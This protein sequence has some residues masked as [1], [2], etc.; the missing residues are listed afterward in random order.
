MV[1]KKETSFLDE[2]LDKYG[3]EVAIRKYKK[4]IPA[5]STGSLGID[6]STGIGGIPK[7][8]F[9][10]IYGADGS[11]KTT[12]LLNIAK[13]ALLAGERVAFIDTENSLDYAYA[14]DIIGDFDSDGLIIIQPESAE[15]SFEIALSAID[16]GYGVILF[17]SVAALS[18][19]KELEN[20]MDKAQVALAPR[21][22]SKFLRKVAFKVRQKEVAFVFTNQVRANM[23][24][25]VG[26]WTTPAGYALKHYVSLKIFLQRSDEIK[27]GEDVIGHFIKFTIKKNKVGKPY[28]QAT[29]NIIWGKGIDFYR[30][31]LSFG[32]LLGVIKNRGSYF[33]F[34]DETIGNK[35]GAANTARALG[36]DKEL[37]DKIVEMCYNVAGSKRYQKEEQ[38]KEEQKSVKRENDDGKNDGG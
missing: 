7:G 25:Y 11:G 4:G 24:S 1:K 18:P 12:L 17:D 14:H 31:V 19:E 6:V 37:L 20:R 38:K 22:T 15:D 36:K 34:E 23:G 3:E 27:D 2:I 8:R 30:D 29:T 21:L 32:T 16:H 26:G 28:R 35:P 5:I 9:T 33:G 10:E 13:Q